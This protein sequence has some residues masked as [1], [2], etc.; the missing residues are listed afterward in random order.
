MVDIPAG[1]LN[2][3]VFTVNDNRP[4]RVFSDN[5]LSG[6]EIEKKKLKDLVN[7]QYK[8]GNSWPVI[9][10]GAQ[11]GSGRY[12]FEIGKGKEAAYTGDVVVY[13]SFI[14]RMR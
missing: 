10:A 11:L 1:T 8:V 9:N 7:R 13:S 6:K 5:T 3:L 4:V 2:D 12:F 14:V